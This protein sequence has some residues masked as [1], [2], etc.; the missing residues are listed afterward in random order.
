MLV[1]K[2][3]QSQSP[4]SKDCLRIPASSVE[5]PAS[6]RKEEPKVIFASISGCQLLR[7]RAEHSKNDR[8]KSLIG[9]GVDLIAK[10]AG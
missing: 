9:S 4:T 10:E 7:E 3:V 1:G 6:R 8:I 5:K 2:A